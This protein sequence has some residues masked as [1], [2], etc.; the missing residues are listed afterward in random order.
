MFQVGEI[1]HHP[2]F[3]ASTFEKN[4]A[5]I[6]LTTNATLNSY[7]QPV[8]LWT[9]SSAMINEMGIVVG[10]GI[11]QTATGRSLNE[12]QQASVHVAA[13]YNCLSSGSETSLPDGT[14]CVAHQQSIRWLC[15][16]ELIRFFINS[17]SI[18]DTID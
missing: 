1:V 7:V 18:R 17:F 16:T 5:I 14:Y 13:Q 12:L 15:I 6:R 11:S 3:D 8:C 10:W 2:S 4:L 9:G